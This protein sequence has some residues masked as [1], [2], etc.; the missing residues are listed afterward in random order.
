LHSLAEETSSHAQ[1]RNSMIR[2]REWK[3]ILS[4]SRPPELYR[5]D[6]GWVERENVADRSEY[7]AI[8]RGFDE[9]LRAWWKW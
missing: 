8:R 5:M 9:R 7:A 6:G 4:E 2:T 1:F 3:F